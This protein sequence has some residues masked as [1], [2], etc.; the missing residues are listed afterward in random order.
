[1]VGDFCC[2][3]DEDTLSYRDGIMSH[4]VKDLANGKLHW[5]VKPTIFYC[6]G[7][8]VLAIGVHFEN[9]LHVA[10]QMMQGATGLCSH[11]DTNY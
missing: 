11:M 6:F 4:F 10:I 5:S 8:I 3:V 1:M 9:Y 7:D 2:A